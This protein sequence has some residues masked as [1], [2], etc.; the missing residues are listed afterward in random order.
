MSRRPGLTLQISTSQEDSGPEAVF[1]HGFD[2]LTSIF[3]KRTGN[4]VVEVLEGNDFVVKITPLGE[5]EGGQGGSGEATA[6]QTMSP[7]VLSRYTGLLDE[8]SIQ[9]LRQINDSNI[10]RL[11]KAGYAVSF[12]RKH[13]EPYETLKELCFGN[14]A[15]EA[16]SPFNIK[17]EQALQVIQELKDTVYTVFADLW[18]GGEV[19]HRDLKVDNVLAYVCP[20]D[21]GIRFSVIDFDLAGKSQGNTENEEGINIVGHMDTKGVEGSIDDAVTRLSISPTRKNSKNLLIAPKYMTPI[22]D[23]YNKR[24]FLTDVEREITSIVTLIES[25][26]KHWLALKIDSSKLF[27]TDKL[28]QKELLGKNQT[29]LFE[30]EYPEKIGNMRPAQLRFQS[31]QLTRKPYP[32]N[33]VEI[34]FPENENP[35]QKTSYGGRDTGMRVVGLIALSCIMFA[36]SAGAIFGY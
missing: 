30:Y 24:Y 34:K 23:D 18:A 6:R 19:L 11:E 7:Q 28:I 16:E 3:S 2:G 20:D 8:A 15:I 17:K 26:A 27:L 29:I 4:G 21:G 1:D 33:A 32:I 10:V 22:P 36:T 14:K 9:T 13:P 12:S 5:G 35:N 31:L 25:A